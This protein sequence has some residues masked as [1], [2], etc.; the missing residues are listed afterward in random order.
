MRSMSEMMRSILSDFFSVWDSASLNHFFIFL[1][2]FFALLAM[3][4]PRSSKPYP[5]ALA[6][7]STTSVKSLKPSWDSLKEER[8]TAPDMATIEDARIT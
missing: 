8:W 6:V 2:V 7:P 4:F 3:S 5:F 1:P